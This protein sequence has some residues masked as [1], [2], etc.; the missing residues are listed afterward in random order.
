MT[1]TTQ[2]LGLV[3]TDMETDGNEL[4]NFDTDLN[5]NWDKIDLQ[6]A[7]KEDL[8]NKANKDLSN[9][10]STGNAKFENKANANLDNLKAAGYELIAES[11]A[12]SNQILPLS[13]GL[14]DTEYTAIAAGYFDITGIC[15]TKSTA[16]VSINILDTN[17]N[18]ICASTEV[19]TPSY[20]PAGVSITTP[21]LP[22]GMKVKIVKS[23][24]ITLSD[25]KFIYAGGLQND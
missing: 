7:K 1:Q 18:P 13:I 19:F 2:N 23:S 15:N 24:N 20:T 21:L 3:K 9:L 10:S 22:K 14:S 16:T 17:S 25:F 12:I 4:F 8:N 11:V 5:Q 6:V